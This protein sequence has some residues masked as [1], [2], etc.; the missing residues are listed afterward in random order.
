MKR[1]ILTAT[2]LLWAMLPSAALASVSREIS[3][4]DTV[5]TAAILTG[6][7][8]E[9]EPKVS[10][11]VGGYTS[12]LHM[13]IFEKP[14]EPWINSSMLHNRLNFKAYAGSKVT[15][16]LELR[17]RFVTGD[18]VALDPSYVSNLSAD[19]GWADL[20][21]NISKGSSYVMN[22][23]IDRAYIDFTAGQ[24]QVRAGRQRINWS[25][26]L[27]WNPNDLF[28]TY[29]FF[30][31]DY[32][33]RPG[34]DA[35]RFIYST[36]P[37]SAVEAAVKVDGSNRITAAALGRFNIF[38]TD[39]QFLAGV[40]D[41]EY[42]TAGTGLSGAIGSVSVRG[43]ATLFAP[44]K[45][46]E[47]EKYNFLATIGVDKTFS[48]KVTALAQVMYSSNPVDI[49]SFN[50]LYG[51]GLTARQLAFSEFSAAG[52]ITCTPFPL[53]SLSLSGIWFP[54][55]DGFYAGPSVDFSLAENVD[56]TFLWQHFKSTL[57]NEETKINLGF[58]RIRYSF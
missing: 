33:E 30:D 51:G 58:I 13:A 24:L 57:A 21:W 25:Q 18:M 31:F 43:E 28:N 16:A 29:S 50:E 6:S 5:K 42:F 53:L 14:S 35:L 37:S 40:T 41:D 7:P 19:A 55:L 27:V 3:A 4:A 20:S 48:D 54:D 15:F 44:L 32:V 8:E 46:A 49:S 39:L 38:N 17:N 22:A 34:S 47:G 2:L 52:Q 10:L 36:G 1:S 9:E 23:M 12:W 11:T 26:A 45:G 56:F